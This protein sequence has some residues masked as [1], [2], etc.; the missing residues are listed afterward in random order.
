MIEPGDVEAGGDQF[1]RDLFEPAARHDVVGHLLTGHPT[2]RSRGIRWMQTQTEH[3]TGPLTIVV[4][5]A[6]LVAAVVILPLVCHF[7]DQSRQH[8]DDGPVLEVQRVPS[9][10]AY[11]A[12]NS[13][14]S[15]P[16]TVRSLPPSTRRR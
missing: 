14:L 7:M 11:F 12:L 8:V 16:S 6:R 10:T 5:A 9:N 15:R 3:F 1:L 2:T 13:M 4:G